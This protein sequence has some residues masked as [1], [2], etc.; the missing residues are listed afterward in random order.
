MMSK[1]ANGKHVKEGKVLQLPCE[2]SNGFF[3]DEYS[4][5][6]VVDDMLKRHVIIGHVSSDSIIQ[7]N[8]S[9]FVSALVMKGLE[10]ASARIFLPG[11]LVSDPNP[12]T[13]PIAWLSRFF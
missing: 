5:Q 13:V 8:G 1:M 6:I 2:V 11:E 3:P 4:Y 9:K 12:V 10:R 7:N